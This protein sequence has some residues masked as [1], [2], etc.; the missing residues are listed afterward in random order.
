MLKGKL[1]D[2][3]HNKTCIQ[4]RKHTVHCYTLVLNTII[5]KIEKMISSLREQIVC[6]LNCPQASSD[7]YYKIS[8]TFC[9][10][11]EQF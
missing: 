10:F 4:V 2:A 6:K 9:A 11:T 8:I 5:I 1:H 7:T 3:P